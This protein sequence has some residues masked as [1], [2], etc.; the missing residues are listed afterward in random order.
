MGNR[1]CKR[2]PLDFDAPLNEIWEGYQRPDYRPCPSDDCENGETIAQAWLNDLTHLILML[3]ED[4]KRP[5]RALHPWLAAVPLRPD[6]RPGPQAVELTAGLAGRAP[7]IFGHDA[8]DRFAATRAVVKAAGLSEDWGICPVCHGHAIHPDDR[9]ASETWESTEPPTGEGWQLWETTTEGSPVSPVFATA[10][11][12][13]DWCAEHA[14][15]FGN[16]MMGRE[17]WLTG[18]LNDTT[19]VDALLVIRGPVER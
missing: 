1:T 9:E 11:A 17:R 14:T 19:D 10:E 16:L 18:F 15:Y 8:C 13:A 3:G 2:V 6:K 12:L 7:S 5:P 4:D